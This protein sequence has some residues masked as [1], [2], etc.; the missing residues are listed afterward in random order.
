MIPDKEGQNHHFVKVNFIFIKFA[1]F[2]FSH[3]VPARSE[4]EVRTSLS[5]YQSCKAKRDS[6]KGVQLAGGAAVFR[7]GLYSP[8]LDWKCIPGTWDF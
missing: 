1:F 5:T 7:G 4:L 2:F 8:P 6:G 3:S